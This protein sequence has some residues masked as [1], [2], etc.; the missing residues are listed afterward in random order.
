MKLGVIFSRTILVQWFE[1]SIRRQQVGMTNVNHFF[2]KLE[3]ERV[4]LGTGTPQNQCLIPLL[5]YV[6]CKLG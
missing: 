3:T 4:A 2:A 6:H 1:K 5:V